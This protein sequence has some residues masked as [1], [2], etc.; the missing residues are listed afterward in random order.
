MSENPNHPYTLEVLPAA[1]AG[2]FQ[3]TLRRHG[4]LIQRSD[5]IHRSEE[6]AQKDGTKAIE[7]QFADSQSAR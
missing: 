5:K 3:W 7:R 2:T 6:D 1:K 4:K